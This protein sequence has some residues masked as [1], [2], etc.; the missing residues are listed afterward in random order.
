MVVFQG[1]EGLDALKLM[2]TLDIV[3]KFISTVGFPIAIAVYV[4]V[5]MEKTIAG[6]TGSL[7]EL[8]ATL[9]VLPCIQTT[10]KKKP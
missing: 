5:R 9:K 3:S 8:S 10:E 7:A 6:L 2:E 4:L 1:E